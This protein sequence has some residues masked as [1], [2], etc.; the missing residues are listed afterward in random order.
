MEGELCVKGDAIMNGYLDNPA[1]T[2]RAFDNEGFLKSG[3]IAYCDQGKWYIVDRKKVRFY[4]GAKAR[5]T[6]T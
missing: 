4:P 5:S 3:D 6:W 1:A 2:A